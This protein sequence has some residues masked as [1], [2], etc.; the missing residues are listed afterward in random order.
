MQC[1]LSVLPPIDPASQD[2][3]PHSQSPSSLALPASDPANAPSC[4]VVSQTHVRV[5]PVTHSAAAHFPGPSNY[6]SPPRC[7]THGLHPTP[8]R[9]HIRSFMSLLRPR[10]ILPWVAL[11]RAHVAR[12]TSFFI[13]LMITLLILPGHP[14]RLLLPPRAVAFDPFT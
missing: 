6:H 3:A 11:T 2:R 13:E 5:P 8:I 9:R 7:H 14:P 1:P 4:A 10:I 12:P